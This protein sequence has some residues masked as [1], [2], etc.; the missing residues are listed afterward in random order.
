M[1]DL[2]G[3]TAGQNGN[4]FQCR[5]RVLPVGL[6]RRP[7]PRQGEC[8]R[9]HRGP[10]GGPQ[11]APAPGRPARRGPAADPRGRGLGQ[12]ARAHPP[13]RAPGRHRPGRAGRDPR[14]HVHQQGRAGDARA[15]GAAG[16][17]AGAGDVGDDLPLGLRA[18]AARRRRAARLHARLHDLR[19]AGLAAAGQELHRGA[20]HRPQAV[21][22]ARD[23][24]PDLGRQ[25]RAA[26]RRG[27]PAQGR[28][29]LRA[30]RR[31]RLRPLRAAP[32]RRERDGLRRPAVPLREPVRAVR[33]GARPLP[34]LVPP[35]A[36]R[37][38][39]GHQPRPVP[40]AA[41]AR[42]G[43]PQPR[44]GRRRRP[45]DLPLPRRRHPQHPRLRGP[46]PR[47][48][49]RQARAELPLDADDPE[50]LQRGHLEQPLAQGQVALVRARRGRPGARA[51]ARG[52]ARRGALRGVGDRAAGGRGRLARRHRRLLPGQRPEPRARGHA[53]ALRRRLP[54]DRRHA[55]LRAR[56][57][58]GRAGLP[59]AAR[60]PVRH[61]RVRADRQLAAARDRPDLAGAPGRPRQHDRRA[62]L[63]GGR[64]A[65][66][67]ARPRH[68]PR[69]RRSA[70]SCR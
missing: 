18:H 61:G 60:Q 29:L 54:G 52:R 13:D 10:A 55:L 63:G 34:A 5:Q 37:R 36:R 21:P 53:G 16:R 65:R 27:L 11:R 12:D 58:Q 22:G 64:R 15:G 38:V 40:L 3:N 4:P 59:D 70:A 6:R 32:A 19:R 14:D 69:S 67:G 39:P 9:S 50:R 7:Y 57:D 49:G 31:R 35:R 33:G 8:T 20:R 45:V 42:R 25:E 66:E 56:R 2:G 44:G 28:Q 1:I 24:P 48:D 43:A 68:A 26:R 51:R 62:G 41:A 30:D 46:L 23:P 47:R 17:P